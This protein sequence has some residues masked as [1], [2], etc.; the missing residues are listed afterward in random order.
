M[1]TQ[2]QKSRASETP[3]GVMEKV[4]EQETLLELRMR[5]IEQLTVGVVCVCYMGGVGGCGQLWVG[6]WV[7]VVSL[8][9]GRARLVTTSAGRWGAVFTKD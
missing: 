7:G 5:E 6:C 4:A 8:V 3:A 9:H 2:L 1:T